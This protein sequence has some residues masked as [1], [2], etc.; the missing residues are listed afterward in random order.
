MNDLEAT[1]A[2]FST[3]ETPLREA[4]NDREGELCSQVCVAA[5]V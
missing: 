5:G 4:I 3:H 2:E 1:A